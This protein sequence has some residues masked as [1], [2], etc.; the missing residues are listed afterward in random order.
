MKTAIITVIT[1]KGEK[2]KLEKTAKFNDSEENIK[3][4]IEIDMYRIFGETQ[5]ITIDF[6]AE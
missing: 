1:R 5:K 3:R 4:A 6:Y 2:H